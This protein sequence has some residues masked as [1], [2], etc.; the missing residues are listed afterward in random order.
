[1]QLGMTAW[2]LAVGDDSLEVGDDSLAAGPLRPLAWHY[3]G[4]HGKSALS[5][6]ADL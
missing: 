6:S 1:M 3:R 5:F 4:M 2:K